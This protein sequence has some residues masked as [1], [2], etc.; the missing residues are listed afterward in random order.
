[1]VQIFPGQKS[2][3]GSIPYMGKK[4]GGPKKPEFIADHY[5]IFSENYLM[6]RSEIK[7]L[8]IFFFRFYIRRVLR[9][10]RKKIK[11]ALFFLHRIFF[12]KFETF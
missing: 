11:N 7:E 1:M 5:K 8:K 10:S 12:F 3:Q 4:K 2:K 6:S 9:T